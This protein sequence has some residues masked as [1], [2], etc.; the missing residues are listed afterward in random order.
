MIPEDEPA[1]LLL[2]VTLPTHGATARMRIWRA[3]KAR[4]CAALRDGAY[5]LPA[6]AD[7]EEA[8]QQLAVEC[9][10]EGGSAWLMSVLPRSDEEQKLFRELFDRGDDYAALRKSWKQANRTLAS[11]SSIELARLQ[12]KL[13]REYEAVRSIDFFTSDASIEAEAAWT[14][15]SRR[16]DQLLSPDE[17]HETRGLVPRLDA[18]KYQGRT[19]ATRRRPWVD[20]VASA[21][22][23]RRFIDK[24][25]RFRWLG[26][27]SDCPKSALGFDFDGATFTHVGDRVTFETLMGSFGLDGDPVLLR[28]ATMVHQLDVG[29]EPVPEAGG[30]EAMLSGARERLDDDDALLAEIGAVLDSLYAHF[31]RETAR[32]G[33]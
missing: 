7:R 6:G 5:L 28:M 3:L 19:W 31:A 27:P 25:A 26:S 17:P 33:T 24:K 15:F 13:Q 10:A 14:D 9:E 32:S 18:S 21:W 30:F 20:R 23:I 22:L 2:V 11:L 16:V 8:L 29:G 1:W 4:G 12:R